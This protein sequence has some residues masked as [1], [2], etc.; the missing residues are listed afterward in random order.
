MTHFATGSMPLSRVTVGSI[1]DLVGRVVGGKRAY[2][3]LPSAAPCFGGICGGLGHNSVKLCLL[4]G[5]GGAT[6]L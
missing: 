3:G 1:E 4:A 5:R 6:L 2:M